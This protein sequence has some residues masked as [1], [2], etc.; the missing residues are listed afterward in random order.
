ML[1]TTFSLLCLEGH[2]NP[3][4]QNWIRHWAPQGECFWDYWGSASEGF[5]LYKLA[6]QG[7]PEK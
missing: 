5:L 6:I 1:I 2:Y 4:E 3:L 7:L